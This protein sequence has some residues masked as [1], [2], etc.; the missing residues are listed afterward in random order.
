MVTINFATATPLTLVISIL[1]VHVC[2]IHVTW[3]FH[4]IRAAESTTSS[5]VIP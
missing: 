5:L 1:S 4:G 2:N 3:P